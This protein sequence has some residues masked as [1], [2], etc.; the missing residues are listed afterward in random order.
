[1]NCGIIGSLFVGVLFSVIINCYYYLMW[2]NKNPID[3][4]MYALF[5]SFFVLGWFDDYFTQTFWL[6]LIIISTVFKIVSK[7]MININGFSKIKFVIRN[8]NIR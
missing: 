3:L 2:K 1:M 8:G 6:Y 5:G 4:I 7:Y